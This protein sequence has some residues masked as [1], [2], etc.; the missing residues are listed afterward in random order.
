MKVFHVLKRRHVLSPISCLFRGPFPRVF[1]SLRELVASSEGATS[2]PATYLPLG[3][4]ESPRILRKG[5]I[6]MSGSTTP[7]SSVA[8][9]SV[10]KW[11]LLS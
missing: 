8:P 9:G 7:V 5:P 6:L 2:E 1:I 3:S 10:D 11:L 4:F